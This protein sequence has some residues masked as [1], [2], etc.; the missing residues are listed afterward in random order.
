[1]FSYIITFIQWH[2]IDLFIEFLFISTQKNGDIPVVYL[3]DLDKE[4]MSFSNND[5]SHFLHGFLDKAKAYEHA[6]AMDSLIRKKHMSMQVRRGHP[7]T[8]KS[9][10]NSE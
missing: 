10:E 9:Y 5:L 4:F 2:V 6:C 3:A 8:C 7:S 1:M